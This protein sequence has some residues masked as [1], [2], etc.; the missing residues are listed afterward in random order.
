MGRAVEVPAA[1]ARIVS[2]VPSITEA[3]FAFG[4]E[5]RIAGVTRFCVEPRERVRGKGRV[6]GTKDPDVAKIAALAPDL[7]LA[8]A[9]ENR[10]EDVEALIN[11]GLTVFVTYPR[12]VSAAIEMLHQVA[13]MTGAAEAA[14]KTVREARAE[15]KKAVSAG[16]RRPPVSVFCAIWRNPW[17]TVGP[18]T[19]MHDMITICGGRNVYADGAQRYP[20]VTLSDVARR[21]PDVVLLP[22]EP[23]R[24]GRKHLPEV[25]ALDMPA[26]VAGRLFFVDGKDLCWY[27]P[28][29]PRAIRTLRRLLDSAR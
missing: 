13:Q 24:F 8:N 19:Y 23:Y 28:R 10:R 25:T 27:G 16:R 18:D 3:L 21:Q 14:A 2:L 1:P 17:M 4:L 9:E 22:D 11:L 29:I 12:T 26:A 5:E 7:V 6:G 20:E 15:L